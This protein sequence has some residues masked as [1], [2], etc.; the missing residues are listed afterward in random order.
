MNIIGLNAFGQNPS[1]CLLIDGKLVSF[2]HE[3]RF[4]RMKGSHGLFPSQ[5]LSWCLKQNNF[6]LEDIDYI[7][8]NWDC[9][10]YP[11]KIFTDL[12]K[13][14]FSKN[15]TIFKKDSGFKN[16]SSAVN[17]LD[18]LVSYNPKLIK[19]KI[20]DNLRMA[21]HGGEIPKIIFVNHHLA[22][23]YQ[24]YY[25]SD[26]KDSLVLV[27]DGHG[28]E[29]C[30]SG[31]KV[32]NENFIKIIGYNIPNSL[33]W[34]YGAF[35]AYLGFHAN[36]DEGKLMGLAAYGEKRKE[37]NPW[38]ERLDKLIQLKNNHLEFDPKFLK[39]GGNYYHP[40]YTNLLV[41]FITS[42][43]QEMVPINVNQ[44]VLH[45]GKQINK[46]LLNKYIDL[47]YAVQTKLEESLVHIVK[48]MVQ[49][50]KIT[51]LAYAGG[52]AL[53]CKANQ[54][55]LAKSGVSEI[56]VHPA[57]SDDG[58][59]IG[60]AFYVARETGDSVRN[61]LKNVQIGASFS[62]DSILKTIKQANLKFKHI[63]NVPTATAKYLEEGNIIGWFQG[64]AEMGPR[65]LGG[66]SII[67]SLNDAI[68]KDKINERVKFRETWRPYCPSI[69]AEEQANFVENSVDTPFMVVAANAKKNL[70]NVAPSI[71]HIDNTI[72]PQTVNKNSNKLWHEMISQQNKLTGIPMVLNTSFN[73]RGEPIVNSPRDAI[74]TFFSC[75]L[76]K[77]VIGNYVI[78]K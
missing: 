73:V 77:L 31:Y 17:I 56:F 63:D 8:F 71:V 47:A 57:S 22:H 64:G 24:A 16:N 53:N 26:F 67:A 11:F 5:A 7:A 46:Y 70:K 42:Y 48:G 61:V 25:Q 50:T 74:R 34:F 75:G 27:A 29:N 15:K 39:Y 4:N 36:R 37:V 41:K 52:V 28:E 54:M 3:E 23:A 10:K 49:Q 45:N 62:N 51:K 65:A 58:S 38:I 60:A 2:S 40:R 68:V 33:G 30:I 43:D 18:H 44:L 9:D 13:S 21:G 69:L 1:A 35:T 14:R 20:R 76:D 78:S 12:V 72:R 19:E 55:I 59:S 6:A 66:R 32:V